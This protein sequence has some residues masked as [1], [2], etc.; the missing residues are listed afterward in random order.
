MWYRKLISVLIFPAFGFWFSGAATAQECNNP[1]F[2]FD[3][4]IPTVV[5]NITGSSVTCTLEPGGASQPF[6]KLD[7]GS[8]LGTATATFTQTGTANCTRKPSNASLGACTFELTWTGVTTTVCTNNKF[9]AKG[10]C[11][12]GSLAV[13]G[14]ITCPPLPAPPGIVPLVINLGIGGIDTESGES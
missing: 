13:T 8:G 11:G 10:S 14:T 4:G 1:D 6:N 7:I 3:F 5:D 9:S 2:C 12:D